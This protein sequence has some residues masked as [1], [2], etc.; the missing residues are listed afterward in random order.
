MLYYPV[1][2][3]EQ[4]SVPARAGSLTRAHRV[5]SSRVVRYNKMQ[6]ER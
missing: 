5:V 1:L 2:G 4:M 3:G 6:P